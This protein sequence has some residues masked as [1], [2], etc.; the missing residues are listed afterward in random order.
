[1]HK[2]PNHDL[3]VTDAVQQAIV[4]DE[5]LPQPWVIDLGTGATA[6]GQR[7]ETAGGVHGSA[8]QAISVVRSICPDAGDHVIECSLRRFGPDY[9]ACPRSHVRRNSASTRSWGVVRPA[10]SSASPRATA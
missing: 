6:L 5:E 7:G 10:R 9:P 8:E 2:G 1:M 3:V 4:E